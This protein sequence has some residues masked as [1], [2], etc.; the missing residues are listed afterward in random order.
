[1][2]RRYL[3]SSMHVF[4]LNL[5]RLEFAAIIPKGE[6]ATVCLLGENIDKA[7]VSSFL[8]APEVQPCFPPGWQ[9]S[10]D[11]CHCSPRINIHPA[12]RPF[13]DRIVF[14]GDCGSTRLYKDGIGAAYRTAKA[15]AATA[16]LHGVAA[17][18]FAR[19]YQPVC[20]AI[21]RDNNFGRLV[22]AMTR[23]TQKNRFLRRGVLRMVRVEQKKGGGPMSAV[24]WNTF[25]GSAPYREIVR[26]ALH[27]AFLSSFVWNI[28]AANTRA[29]RDLR[30][31]RQ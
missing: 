29:R 17:E 12:H 26:N 15:A 4:L 2:V 16:L 30:Q 5:P 7:L 1:M 23:V 22:F 28:L 8:H 10:G 9:Q 19:H 24:L 6:Y 31:G 14:I 18:D 11:Y 27:P 3:G 25:T 20:D 13:A 21:A